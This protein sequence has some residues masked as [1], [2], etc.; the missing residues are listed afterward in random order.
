VSI[1]ASYFELNY[2]VVHSADDRWISMCV[3]SLAHI[4]IIKK[5]RYAPWYLLIIG[6]RVSIFS[7]D[8]QVTWFPDEL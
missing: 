8:R 3:A 7:L 5:D 4:L 1:L 6:F 2:E